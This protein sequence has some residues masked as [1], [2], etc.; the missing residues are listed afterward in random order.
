LLAAPGWFEGGG[1]IQH[2][3][4]VEVEASD[5]V[6][7]SRQRRLLLNRDSPAIPVEFDN[8]IPLR[9]VHLVAKQGRPGPP[10]SCPRE[11][12]GQAVTVKDVVTKNKS[13]WVGDDEF[14]ATRRASATPRGSSCVA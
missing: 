1:D 11:Q 5:S 2:L 12:F 9:I 10:L 8:S 6:V 3:I 7:R 13:N 4:V 14:T